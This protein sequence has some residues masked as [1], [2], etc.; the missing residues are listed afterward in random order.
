MISILRVRFSFRWPICFK[1][2]RYTPSFFSMLLISFQAVFVD[3]QVTFIVIHNATF[4]AEHWSISESLVKRLA[5]LHFQL[6][7]LA[8]N[9]PRSTADVSEYDSRW[10][11]HK[12]LSNKMD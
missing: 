1:L 4:L 8:E 2:G 6:S 9:L 3:S 7:T 11:V 5:S 12:R 10:Y